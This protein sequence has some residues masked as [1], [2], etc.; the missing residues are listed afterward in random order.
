M[1][2]AQNVAIGLTAEPVPPGMANGA[3]V[4]TNSWVPSATHIAR[5]VVTS[6]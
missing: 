3:Q 2:A 1:T 6:G 4:R 5:N